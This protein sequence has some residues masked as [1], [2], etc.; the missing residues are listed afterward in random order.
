MTVGGDE[1]L[2]ISRAGKVIG[3][4]KP[5]RIQE[6]LVTGVLLRTDH[7]WRPGMTGWGRLDEPGLDL[8][9]MPVVAAPSPYARA[10]V[11]HFDEADAD[12]DEYR[13]W[14]IFLSIKIAAAG[15][16]LLGVAS[17]AVDTLQIIQMGQSIG[18]RYSGSY[19][20][21]YL[22]PGS[23]GKMNA[24]GYETVA[25]FAGW[26]LCVIIANSTHNY[27]VRKASITQQLKS[28]KIS[29]AK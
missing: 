14:T 16:A 11:H 2:R 8:S 18:S 12:Q 15:L 28:L 27:L 22:R 7:Y 5:A 20:Y 6:L 17:A 13:R 3:A 4:F 24:F 9:E 23:I 21:S 29:T 1:E 10:V 26:L 19:E 25:W